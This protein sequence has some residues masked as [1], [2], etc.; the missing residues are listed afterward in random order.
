MRVVIVDDMLL[1][2]DGLAASLGHRGIDVV[3]AAEDAEQLV[4]LVDRHRAD[5]VVLDIRM[6]PTFTDEGLTAAATLRAARPNV[7]ILLLSQYLESSY[8]VRLLHD[9]PAKV[10]YLLKDRVMHASALVDALRRVVA[11]ETVIDPAIVSRVIQR[12]RHGAGLA[13]LSGRE[14]EV[15]ALVAEGL[16]NRAIAEQLVINERT[17]ETHITQIF[18]KLGLV[19]SRDLHRRVLAVLML[20]RSDR[21]AE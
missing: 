9:A 20:L 16:S 17:V 1:I 2:R 5:A 21:V 19:D 6:P 8:A 7:G 11:G 10:G 15:L 14:A 3:A 4:D 12:G 13:D 18:S